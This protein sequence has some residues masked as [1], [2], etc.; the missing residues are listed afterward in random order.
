MNAMKIVTDGIGITLSDWMEWK[1]QNIPTVV[2]VMYGTDY[3][4]IA[5]AATTS[6]D[7]LWPHTWTDDI[8][9]SRTPLLV[10]E[11]IY[12][13]QST[14]QQQSSWYGLYGLSV[15]FWIE[16]VV[17]QLLVC[18]FAALPIAIFMYYIIIVPQ[19]QEYKSV[20]DP[21][22]QTRGTTAFGYMLGWFILLPIW[23]I[24]P[25]PMATAFGIENA[26]HR[27]FVCGTTP[28]LAI[29]RTLEA[30]YGFAPTASIT[31][32]YN[33]ALYFT[34]PLLLNAKTKSKVNE[35]DPK[36]AW[37]T[38][39]YHQAETFAS[40]LFVTGMYQSYIRAIVPYGK[41]PASTPSNLYTWS[42]LVDS[43]IWY[44]TISYAFLL[45]LYLATC[46]SGLALSTMILTGYSTQ[47][48]SDAP[49]QH[50]TS[51]S[52]FWGRRWN[53]LIHTCLKNGVF[54]PIRSLGGHTVVAVVA[55]F[56][57][58]GVFHEWLLP[59]T[60]TD[61]PHTHGLA[62]TFFLWN[63]M[64]VAMEMM[65]GARVGR[66]FAGIK[67]YIPRPCIT[68]A[69]IALGL[70]V[71]HWFIDSY[72]RSDFFKHGQFCFPMILSVPVPKETHISIPKL[73]SFSI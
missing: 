4:T 27:F 62:I 23:I 69:V 30:M 44:E 48:I 47:P 39:L 43:Q 50:C 54:K 21:A 51:P 45:Q 11:F 8:A 56:I 15:L 40:G 37:F 73:L 46:S 58:S 67:P 38:S 70:P 7:A 65:I 6:Y 63:A 61:Y 28:T 13:N 49:L 17:I 1:L 24:L 9:T 52:D 55:T 18:L 3:K 33:Y 20:T 25:S 35:K 26:I 60:M 22:K 2:T 57:A 16:L 53:N 31:S 36:P 59:S 71:G 5:S 72:M 32:V 42:S 41:G 64:L 34:S 14:T 19:K 12:S 10:F 29:F 66:M 68:I